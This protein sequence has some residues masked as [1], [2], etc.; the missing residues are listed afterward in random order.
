VTEHDVEPRRHFA[1]ARL[2]DRGEV[3]N[4]RRA[5]LRIADAS[6]NA[7]PVVLRMALDVALRRQQLA[8]CLLIL[9]WM[10]GVR[11]G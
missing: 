8:V 9:K 2:F 5:G 6:E 1:D 4:E 10:C 3:Y 7:V 11:P